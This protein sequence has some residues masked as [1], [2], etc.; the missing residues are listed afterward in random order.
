M[1]DMVNRIAPIAAVVTAIMIIWYGFT[2][3]LNAPWQ[4]ERYEKAGSEWQMADLVRD[5]MAQDRP[6]LP[7]PHQIFTEIW[8]TT[9]K[10]KITSKRSLIYHGSITLSSTLLGFAMGTILGRCGRTWRRPRGSP[11]FTSW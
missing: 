9:V 6:I 2:V 10:K 3:H 8:N 4:I 1:T 5:T 7:A 11:T